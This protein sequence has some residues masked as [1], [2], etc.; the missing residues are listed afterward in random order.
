MTVT[1]MGPRRI[2]ARIKVK[3]QL[4]RTRMLD[5]AAGHEDVIA[6]GRFVQQLA[7]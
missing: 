2:A 1:A 7:A 4:I 5:I 3:E 6:L